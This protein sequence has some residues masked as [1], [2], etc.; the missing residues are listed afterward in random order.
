MHVC[1][2]IYIYIYIYINTLI[3]I[4]IMMRILIAFQ[5]QW[6]VEAR[7]PRRGGAGRPAPGQA[8]DMI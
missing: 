5:R 3:V 4:M 2:Y 1:I 8:C 7:A 6:P